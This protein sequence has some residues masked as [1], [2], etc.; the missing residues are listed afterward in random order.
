MAKYVGKIFEVPNVHLRI[1]GSKT[2]KVH[3]KWYNPF[4]RKFKCN[5]LTS[6]EEKIPLTSD[7]RK[8]MHR[9]VGYYDKTSDTFFQFDKGKYA[10]IRNG[11]I[12]LIPRDKLQ[13]FE[14]WSG[15]EGTRYL[16]KNVLEGRL[17]N[18]L[19]IKK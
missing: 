9:K 4:K 12:M 6:L 3:V 8:G 1:K 17:K 15:Y 10:K 18:E 13:G 2:H 19:K 16:S 14:L 7:N 11:K 5:V